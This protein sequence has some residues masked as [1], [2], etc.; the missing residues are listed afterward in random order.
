M[1]SANLITCLGKN[2]RNMPKTSKYLTCC[3]ELCW[4]MGVQEKPMHLDVIAEKQVGQ[5]KQF[6]TDKFRVYTKTGQYVAYVVW[7]TLFLHEG[8]AML[9]KGVAQGCQDRVSSKE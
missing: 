6:D 1:L 7:P 4:K 9:N 8:G 2:E 3:T 5:D